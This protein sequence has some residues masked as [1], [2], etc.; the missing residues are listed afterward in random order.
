MNEDHASETAANAEEFRK[1]VDSLVGEAEGF[2]HSRTPNAKSSSLL[3]G[4]HTF[5]SQD[6]GTEHH[7]SNSKHKMSTLDLTLSANETDPENAPG[8]DEELDE[9]RLEA[10]LVPDLH[11]PIDRERLLRAQLRVLDPQPGVHL[12]SS[13]ESSE[14]RLEQREFHERARMAVRA[15]LVFKVS[16]RVMMHNV[17]AKRGRINQCCDLFAYLSFFVLFIIWVVS[18]QDIQRNFIVQDGLSSRISGLAGVNSGVT[19][20]EMNSPADYYDYI[21]TALIPELFADDSSDY[22]TLLAG[23]KLTQH[24]INST[25]ACRTH[26]RFCGYEPRMWPLSSGSALHF[27]AASGRDLSESG[28]F[29]TTPFGPPW[30]PGK[31]VWRE[32]ADGALGGAAGGYSILLPL[33]PM[34]CKRLLA[35]LVEDNWFDTDTHRIFTEAVVYHASHRVFVHIS[36]DTTF[37]QSGGLKTKLQVEP[38]NLEQGLVRR[39]L[40]FLVCVAV[41]GWAVYE[42]VLILRHAVNA[43]WRLGGT[44]GVRAFFVTMRLGLAG[45]LFVMMVF[46][47][48]MELGE[49]SDPEKFELPWKEDREEENMKIISYF[50]AYVERRWRVVVVCFFSG[51][52]LIFNLF[53]YL[54]PFPEFG[55]FIHTVSKAGSQLIMYVVMMLMLIFFIA[56]IG[57][58]TFGQKLEEW[59]TMPNALQ[60]TFI[61]VT[62]EYDYT[63]L[64]QGQG[65]RTLGL[66][67]FDAILL[68]MQFVI[69]N[70][71]FQSLAWSCFLH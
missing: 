3:T 47:L 13:A 24:R 63:R 9:E 15:G 36:F 58:Y 62:F 46:G 64:E 17:A 14:A 4:A 33:D 25:D 10:L 45:C 27:A 59:S 28:G 41:I 12:M 39:I 2:A 55:I 31:Y 50:S 34:Y 42:V 37:T 8:L 35:E 48:M 68:I 18:F 21:S 54:L 16:P 38:I 6:M 57:F 40:S 29:E 32:E 71:R 52:L 56:V 53:F 26:P 44:W 19:Y 22:L 11:S 51:I 70:V 30:D 61:I 1:I 43:P 49:L 67:F 60:T 20:E 5:G 65:G 7:G 69:F 66:I 23:L